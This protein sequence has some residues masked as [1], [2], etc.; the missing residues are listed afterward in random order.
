MDSGFLT[1]HPELFNDRAIPQMVGGEPFWDA[2]GPLVRERRL[3]VWNLFQ[4]RRAAASRSRRAANAG[5]NLADPVFQNEIAL[6]NPTQ[7]GS[8]NKAFE[9][10]IQQQM[11]EAARQH[12]TRRTQE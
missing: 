6:A 1:A 2:Q 12:G 4:Y 10:L 5:P 11:Q 7:S 9:M 8:V 3:F